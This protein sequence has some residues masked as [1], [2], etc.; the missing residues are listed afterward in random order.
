MTEIRYNGEELRM[1][2]RGHS[3]YAP[4]GRDIVCAGVSAVCMV[5][6]RALTGSA[7]YKAESKYE[8]ASAGYEV[9]CAPSEKMAESCRGIMEAAAWSLERIAAAYPKNVRYER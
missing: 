4:V 9:S 6:D 3:G 1:S 7:E 5:L 2:V 8:K